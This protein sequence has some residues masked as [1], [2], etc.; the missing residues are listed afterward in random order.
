MKNLWAIGLIALFF[1]GCPATW[2]NSCKIYLQQGDYARAKEQALIGKQ[3]QPDNYLV[4]TLLGKAEIGLNNYLGAS[5]AFHKAFELD[6]LKTLKWLKSDKENVSVYWQA[7]YNAAWT[8]T[9][10]KKYEDALKTLALCKLID[11][12]NVSQYILEGN[13]YIELGDKTK[14]MQAFKNALKQDPEYAEAYYSIGNLY[15]D[16]QE[17]D[18]AL[19]YYS[20]AISYFEKDYNKIKGALFKNVGY[21][22]GIAQEMIRLWNEKRKE[23]LDHLLKVKLGIDGGLEAQSRNVEKFVKSSGGLG[24]SYY[25]SGMSYYSLKNDSLALK[26][27]K[28]AIEYLPDNYNALLFAGELL[29]RLSKWSEAR[30]LFEE[31]S[32]LKPDNFVIWFYLGVCYAQEKNFKKAIEVYEEKAL[33]LEPKNV[34]LLTNLAYA[35]REIGNTKKALEYLKKIEELK[36]E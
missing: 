2:E 16:N 4:Y 19:H 8:F 20:S 23:E 33:P 15:F 12:S 26:N 27:L 35:Y 9:T 21:E 36:K 10:E 17:Y 34:D 24:Q 5:E 28:M 32:V 18:S 11:S 25:F 3:E 31:A 30:N 1:I 22:K 7:L 29:I 6:S 14:G 13:A